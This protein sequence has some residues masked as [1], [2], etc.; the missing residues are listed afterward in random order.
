MREIMRGKE[1][2]NEDGG[3]QTVR[4]RQIG[5]RL[6]HSFFISGFPHG[7]T[8]EDLWGVASNLGK[9]VDAYVSP[10]RRF[11]KEHFGF[12]R[13]SNVRDVEGLTRRLN[14][15]VMGGRKISVNL[16]KTPRHL[17]FN[18]VQKGGVK[19]MH[20]RNT[21]CSMVTGVLEDNH[22]SQ[23]G[24]NKVSF[25][26]MVAGIKTVQSKE[27]VVVGG[28]TSNWKSF[29]I[30]DEGG[31]YPSSFFGRSLLGEAKDGKSLCSVK[32]LKTEGIG[33]DF[34]VVYVGGLHVLLVFNQEMGARKFLDTN[35]QWWD[36][37]LCS[38][39]VWS[40][41]AFPR[42][43]IVG[44]KILGVPL[45]LRDDITYDEIAKGFG[46]IV[47][48][49]QSSWMVEDCTG[50]SV[51]V[52]SEVWKSIDESVQISWKN[53]TYIVMV[54]EDPVVWVPNF[55]DEDRVPSPSM[56]SDREHVG[57]EEEDWNDGDRR[58]DWANEEGG[59]LDGLGGSAMLDPERL[60]Q[61]IGLSLNEVFSCESQVQETEENHVA[62]DKVE[63]SFSTR[64][65]TLSI[66]KETLEGV[67]PASVVGKENDNGPNKWTSIDTRQI[68]SAPQLGLQPILPDL[69]DRAFSS[70]SGEAEGIIS[71]PSS[72]RLVSKGRNQ[73]SGA[74]C[75]AESVHR[76]SGKMVFLEEYR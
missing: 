9:M 42:L 8:A 61:G 70:A 31:V 13:F 7:T 23:G 51:Q 24:G 68:T 48:P 52:L 64:K 28:G 30:P 19:E 35:K 65:S 76:S 1:K 44:L 50:G 10:K 16:A 37:Y 57:D 6:T 38:L 11:N 71:L 75:L 15:I 59:Y 40:G 56:N 60:D 66:T 14:E 62:G 72:S 25:R 20:G 2:E 33:A 22:N 63:G 53:I 3:W 54:K 34:D 58:E 67:D 69:N 46:K 41:H 18:N 74:G 32:L 49:S 39:E 26:D 21:V 27:Q 12:I 45:H 36:T 17:G 55:Y 43:R 4:R 73:R 5:N 29:T 47:W